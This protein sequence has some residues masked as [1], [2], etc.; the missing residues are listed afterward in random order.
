[1]VKLGRHDSVT[2]DPVETKL[3]VGDYVVYRPIIPH[4]MPSWHH[5]DL[6]MLSHP[7]L[8]ISYRHTPSLWKSLKMF[9]DY[10]NHTSAIPITLAMGF[11]NNTG[12]NTVQYDPML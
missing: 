1:M 9:L 4:I 8:A 10:G 11:Y 2:P 6:H 7:L 3:G 12:C 5:L